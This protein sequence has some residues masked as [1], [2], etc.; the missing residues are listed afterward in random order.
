MYYTLYKTPISKDNKGCELTQNIVRYI[1]YTYAVDIR[2]R[3][4]IERNYPSIIKN[5][6]PSLFDNK[7]NIYYNGKEAD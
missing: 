6:L 3:F 7:N 2:P 5:E 4:I 1:H